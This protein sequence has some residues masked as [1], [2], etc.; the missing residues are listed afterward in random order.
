MMIKMLKISS[1]I[2]AVLA[3]A[4]FA[5]PAISGANDKEA[6][7]GGYVN[8]LEKFRQTHDSKAATQ[9]GKPP[10]VIEAEKFALYLD[11]PAPKAPPRPQNTAA[12]QTVASAPRPEIVN[13]KYPLKGTCY[14][15]D[16]PDASFALIDIPGKG[17]R[18]K[19]QGSKIDHLVIEEIRDGVVVY[20]DGT[21][22][23]EEHAEKSVEQNM[24]KAI[25]HADGTREELVTNML[26]MPVVPQI[27]SNSPVSVSAPPQ[28]PQSSNVVA[29]SP[30]SSRRKTA[31]P[32]PAPP[33]ASENEDEMFQ[34]L[35]QQL[36][37][38]NEEAANSGQEQIPDEL[39]DALAEGVGDVSVSP[40]ES[41][42]LEVLGEDLK[43]ESAPESE[44]PTETVPD[45]SRSRG[46]R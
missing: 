27:N 3:I 16:N 9:Q 35:M 12:S 33:A 22:T 4:I 7:K 21:R 37:E 41:A 34:K 31:S 8:V 32:R 43:E 10:L 2:L 6:G 24:V 29:N 28:T 23:F 36:E 14:S 30:T 17:L 20:S 42:E 5:I 40:E 19:K 1:V 11:P 25:I 44:S 18:W 26:S 39:F 13:S 45:I 46:R 38:M 15:K